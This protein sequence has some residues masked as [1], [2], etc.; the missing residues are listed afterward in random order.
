M[1]GTLVYAEAFWRHDAIGPR[2]E[3][4]EPWLRGLGAAYDQISSP[5]LLLVGSR[6]D[7]VPHGVEVR[8]ARGV[9]EL[10][11]A[12][13]GVQMEWLNCGHFAQLERPTEVAASIDRFI[14]AME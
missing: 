9:R 11:G 1:T 2:V 8:E 3:E 13:P 14:G 12:H 7:R 10:Q 4:N 5:V 6:P